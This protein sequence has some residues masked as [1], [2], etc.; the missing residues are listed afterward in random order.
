NPKGHSIPVLGNLFGTPERV[1][2]GMGEESVAALREVGRLLALLK[3]PDPPKG[4]KDAWEKLPLFRKVLDM[5]PKLI[6]GAPCQDVVIEGP[7]VDLSRF[8]IQTCWPDDAGPL[9][10]WA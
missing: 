9:I 1:A 10:T 5:A 3:E 4:M 6:K 8:P 7:D 2:L